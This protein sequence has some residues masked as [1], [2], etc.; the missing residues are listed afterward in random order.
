MP[1]EANPKD[2]TSQ[3][4]LLFP[5]NG[6]YE[7]KMKIQAIACLYI[8]CS[9]IGQILV[10]CMRSCKR[11]TGTYQQ[12]YR[13]WHTSCLSLLSALW[14]EL[15]MHISKFLHR[16]KKR[17]CVFGDS[18]VTIRSNSIIGF[19]ILFGEAYSPITAELVMRLG[20][21]AR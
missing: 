3:V 11:M 9:V 1:V 16:K 2:N 15:V 4:A 17:F 20:S 14:A 13:K 12:D 19:P 21:R 8:A 10:S 7:Y 5:R 6:E 18:D